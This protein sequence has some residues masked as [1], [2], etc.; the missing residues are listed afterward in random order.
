M[1]YSKMLCGVQFYLERK[2]SM[3][4]GNNT[5]YLVLLDF[6]VRVTRHDVD[7]LLKLYYGTCHPTDCFIV[8]V[9]ESL[10][11]ALIFLFE[12]NVGVQE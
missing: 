6:Y 4:V 3:E 1:K 10:Y 9:L 7:E 12:G 2:E 8:E 11:I 5:A